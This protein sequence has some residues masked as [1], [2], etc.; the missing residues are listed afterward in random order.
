MKFLYMRLNKILRRPRIDRNSEARC[1]YV[2]NGDDVMRIVRKRTEIAEAV[3]DTYDES[4]VIFIMP[5]TGHCLGLLNEWKWMCISRMIPR[6]F[7]SV[8]DDT[9]RRSFILS[10]RSVVLPDAT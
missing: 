3:S 5:Y 7:R 9:Y 10:P 2:I 1:M 8:C 4:G 6:K